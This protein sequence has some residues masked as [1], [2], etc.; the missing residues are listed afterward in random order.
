MLIK[1]FLLRSNFSAS[2]RSKDHQGLLL[3]SDVKDV[4][5]GNRKP[6]P[7][8]LFLCNNQNEKSELNDQDGNI[9]HPG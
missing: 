1:L 9:L 5:E 4:K 8:E 6:I 3:P 2:T 7:S